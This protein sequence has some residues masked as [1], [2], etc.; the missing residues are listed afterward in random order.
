MM[1][2]KPLFSVVSLNLTVGSFDWATAA[3]A[4]ASRH[5]QN[6]NRFNVSFTFHLAEVMAGSRDKLGD[7]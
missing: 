5:K 7:R 3:E 4:S 6:K 2:R 1:T